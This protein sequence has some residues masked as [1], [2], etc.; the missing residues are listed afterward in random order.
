MVQPIA[1]KLQACL[2]FYCTKQH[3]IK[4]STRENDATKRHGK[5]E[6]YKA[7]ACVTWHAVL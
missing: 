1:P 7:A 6:M 4:A 2:T 5:Y 3:E